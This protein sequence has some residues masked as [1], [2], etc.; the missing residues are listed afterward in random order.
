MGNFILDDLAMMENCRASAVDTDMENLV[1]MVRIWKERHRAYVDFNA[2]VKGVSYTL[3]TLNYDYR[4][5]LAHWSLD[6]HLEM[7]N[8]LTVACRQSFTDGTRSAEVWLMERA[9]E[10]IRDYK[11]EV[12]LDK[13]LDYIRCYGESAQDYIDQRKREIH[14][15]PVKTKKRRK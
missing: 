15:E 8:H 12:V 6:A 11:P 3:K 7:E 9:E 10:F 14:G 1:Q 13:L 2:S 4:L 5:A